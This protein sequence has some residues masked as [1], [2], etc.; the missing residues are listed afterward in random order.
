MTCKQAKSIIA[1]WQDK[2]FDYSRAQQMWRNEQEPHDEWTIPPDIELV[3]FLLR[4]LKRSKQCL[5]AACRYSRR[6]DR[7]P[8]NVI[9]LWEKEL[10]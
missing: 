3:A 8:E 4:K 9:Q 10:I 5:R 7:V 6:E 1:R 2:K